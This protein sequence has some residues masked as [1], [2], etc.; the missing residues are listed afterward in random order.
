MKDTFETF[1]EIGPYTKSNLIQPEPGAFNGNVRVRKYKVT[2][3]LVAESLE[4]IHARIQKLWSECE[5][6]H[7]WDPI[8]E[9]AKKYGLELQGNAGDRRRKEK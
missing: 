4:V 9:E 1:R 7:H 2:V 5:N 3:E 8:Q 6:H